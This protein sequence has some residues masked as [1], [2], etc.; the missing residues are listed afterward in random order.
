M[1]ELH[2]PPD[3]AELLHRLQRIVEVVDP[4]PADV[5]EVGRAVFALRD[6]HLT[7]L[8]VVSL[9]AELS[10]VRSSTGS[11]RLHFFEHGSVSI[12]VEV[13]VQEP[14]ARVLGAVV[15][16]V[17]DDLSGCRVA[18]ETADSSTTVDLEQGRFSFGRVPLGLARLVLERGGHREMSTAWFEI[19]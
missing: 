4:V 9:P 5:V 16:T 19:G 17:D 6:P 2:L 1:S 15:D 14:F 11:S 13:T 7:R 3:D 18:V 8:E 12:D 10:A